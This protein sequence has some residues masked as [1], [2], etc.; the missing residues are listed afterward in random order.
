MTVR[1]VAEKYLSNGFDKYVLCKLIK[2]SSL[3]I[4]NRFILYHKMYG[5]GCR[6]TSQFARNYIKIIKSVHCV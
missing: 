2:L 6:K 5:T 1:P 4:I 3:T